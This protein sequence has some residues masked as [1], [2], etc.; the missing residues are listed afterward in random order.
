MNAAFQLVL[1]GSVRVLVEAVEI[2]A[3]A[4]FVACAQTNELMVNLSLIRSDVSVATFVD[5]S[6]AA[7][8][9]IA[10]DQSVLNVTS[11]DDAS[12]GVVVALRNAS[13]AFVNVSE[14]SVSVHQSGAGDTP[15]SLV[16]LT[17]V[18]AAAVVVRVLH[19]SIV[20]SGSVVSV[21]WVNDTSNADISITG[22][23]ASLT[24]LSG[25]GSL[26]SWTQ[27]IGGRSPNVSLTISQCSV[28]INATTVVV[29]A[30]ECCARADPAVV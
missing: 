29:I 28:F 12:S 22:I 1:S 11:S 5:V 30:A 3:T 7:V 26:A 16:S 2:N 19:L 15:R 13:I 17:N 4:F 18:R 27:H 6:D 14:S 23:Q 25:V 21:V 9:G 20:S 8:A 10:I 24:S